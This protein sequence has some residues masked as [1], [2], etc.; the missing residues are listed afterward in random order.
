MK[1][2]CY[3][4]VAL[5]NF[6]ME[7]THAAALVW[8]GEEGCGLPWYLEQDYRTPNIY[9]ARYFKKFIQHVVSRRWEVTIP[10]PM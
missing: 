1:R 10:F 2:L 5:P 6:A 8:V 7:D 3:S 9:D 4:V